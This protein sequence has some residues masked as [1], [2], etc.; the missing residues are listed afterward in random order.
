MLI[1]AAVS[2]P[3]PTQIARAYT[4]IF[5]FYV[6]DEEQGVA[7][8]INARAL[9]CSEADKADLHKI[10]PGRICRSFNAVY[11]NDGTEEMVEVT[12]KVGR[13]DVL[14]QTIPVL[15][16]ANEEARSALRARIRK[17]KFVL[18]KLHCAICGTTLPRPEKC[19][20]CGTIFDQSTEAV[21]TVPLGT[22]N[23]PKAIST[24]CF[25][26]GEAMLSTIDSVRKLDGWVLDFGSGL[27]PRSEDRV[28]CLEIADMPS[29]DV[30]SVGPRIP[31][32]DDT[33][34]AVISQHVLEHVERPWETAKE[35]IRVAKPGAIIQSTVPYVCPVHGFPNHF[36][37]MTPDG[38]RKLFEGTDLISHTMQGDAHPIN[39]IKQLLQVFY[40]TLAEPLRS[41]FGATT[42]SEIVA[43]DLPTLVSMDW[44]RALPEA[45]WWE[46]PA[47][48]TLV[49]R[50]RA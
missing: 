6:A 19:S 8:T 26:Y 4:P 21:S 31:F 3:L 28:I 30:V 29:V 10:Y 34:D 16:T 25:G 13:N 27:Q 2:P 50:K 1:L 40:G 33:F 11:V 45:A 49:V 38:L 43:L 12:V 42:V 9:H 47:H 23:I 18:D 17:S 5:G 44:A 39:G 46:M 36:F 15:P 37:N 7:I 35:L 41:K 48:S 22:F 14:K 20:S 32:G 24:S